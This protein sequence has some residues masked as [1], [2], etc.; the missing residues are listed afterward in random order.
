VEQHLKTC[1]KCKSVMSKEGGMYVCDKCLG[2][3][4][5]IKRQQW[6][7]E[8][9]FKGSV[10]KYRTCDI[11]KRGVNGVNVNFKD[12]DIKYICDECLIDSQKKNEK[13]VSLGYVINITEEVVKI[14][15]DI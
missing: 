9:S 5:R 6:E 8:S 4:I 14:Y 1:V 3:V 10:Q 15:R 13:I 12:G 7:Q 2:E 11:C